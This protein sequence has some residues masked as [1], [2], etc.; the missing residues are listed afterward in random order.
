MIN[1]IQTM[2]DAPFNDSN[3]TSKQEPY[4]LVRLTG[5]NGNVVYPKMVEDGKGGW[6]MA[7]PKAVAIALGTPMPPVE[8]P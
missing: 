7:D 1:L 6:K 4:P 2:N 5:E 8:N 3:Q